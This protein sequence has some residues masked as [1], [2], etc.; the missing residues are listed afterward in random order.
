MTAITT[1][2]TVAQQIPPTPYNVTHTNRETRV[3]NLPLPTTPLADSSAVLAAA[4]EA[5]LRDKDV[6]CGKDSALQ[7]DVLSAPSSLKELGAK[8]EGRHVL[9]DGLSVL[10]HADYIPQISIDPSFLINS[11]IDQHAMLIEWKSRVYVLSGA[12]FDEI[13]YEGGSRQYVVHRLFLLDLRFSDQRREI[14]I[15]NDSGDLKQVQGFLS[16]SVERK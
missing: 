15:N 12:L 10:V 1:G 2:P 11:L 13:L 16:L 5:V 8:I 7:D 4:I 3:A 6:C 9:S 14:E